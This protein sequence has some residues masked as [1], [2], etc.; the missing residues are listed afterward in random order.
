[1]ESEAGITASNAL[2]TANEFAV[3][4][5][6]VY[7]YHGSVSVDVTTRLRKIVSYLES[8]ESYDITPENT[9]G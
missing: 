3:D 7:P 9:C 5:F 8:V 1:V 2:N 4:Q 6:L